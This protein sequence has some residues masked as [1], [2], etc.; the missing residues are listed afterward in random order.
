[1]ASKIYKGSPNRA[2]ALAT[3][4]LVINFWAWS[5]LAPLGPQFAS[6]LNLSPL[7]LSVLLAIPIIIG[8]LGRIIMGGLAD[9]YGGRKVLSVTSLLAIIPVLILAFADSYSMLMLG[10]V[11][12]GVGGASFAAGVPYINAWFPPERR[13]FV[14]GIYGMGNVGTAVAGFMTP[15]LA[16]AYS[17]EV[18]YMVVAILLLLIGLAIAVWG[19]NSP[20]WKPPKT[21][22][23]KNLQGAA[24]SRNTWDLSLVYAISFGAFVAFGVYLPVLLKVSYDLSLTDAAT[25]AAGFILLATL[26]RPFGGWASDKIGGKKVIRCVL[27]ATVALASFVALQPTL[28]PTTTIAYLSLALALGSGNGAV[29]ALVSQMAKPGTVG[30]VTGIVGACGGLGGFLPPLVL[31]ASY[32]MTH[33]YSYALLM[34]AVSAAAVFVYINIRFRQMRPAK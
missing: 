6:D 17:R 21:S 4:A 27:I 1:M 30:S 2:L 25:R 28:A 9:R 34:L 15:R 11:F 32:Q 33:S 13:G 10:G 8:S 26:A 14:L 5:L 18:A 31:A 22:F 29:L 19:R 7:K 12:V 3:T 20:T 16:T 24:I 23:L